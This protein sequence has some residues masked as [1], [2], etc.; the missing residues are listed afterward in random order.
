MYSEDHP[1]DS[2]GWAVIV[3]APGQEKNGSG[4]IKVGSPSFLVPR[5]CGE[6][7]VGQRETCD[8]DLPSLNFFPARLVC[9]SS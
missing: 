6:K 5:T 1:P 8:S 9:Y 4:E 3:A 7:K 2:A